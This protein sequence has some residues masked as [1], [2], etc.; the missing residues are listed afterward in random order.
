[1]GRFAERIIQILQRKYDQRGDRMFGK[2]F[3]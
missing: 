1:M 2:K 3:I